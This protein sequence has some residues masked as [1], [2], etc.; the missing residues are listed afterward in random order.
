MTA[1]RCVVSLPAGVD[2]G[3]NY[4]PFDCCIPRKDRY[5]RTW[6]LSQLKRRK[7]ARTVSS[8]WEVKRHLQVI[9]GS[10]AIPF[11]KREHHGRRVGYGE[12]LQAGEETLEC[13]VTSSKTQPEVHLT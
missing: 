13:V 1:A 6:I 9:S 2:S 10:C 5:G 3:D 4:P 7:S 11:F 12:V 8:A